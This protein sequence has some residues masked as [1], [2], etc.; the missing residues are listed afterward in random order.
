MGAPVGGGEPSAQLKRGLARSAWSVAA[1]RAE[2]ETHVEVGR[3]RWKLC[4]LQCGDVRVHQR[5]A[6]Q[7]SFRRSLPTAGDQLVAQLVAFPRMPLALDV[8]QRERRFAVLGEPGL[9]ALERCAELLLAD[10]DLL[11]PVGERWGR[12]R[13]H[14]AGPSRGGGRGRAG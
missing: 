14:R 2:V 9:A 3:G 10:A 5:V 7:K 1:L 12:A 11:V 4:G 8:E 13:R 6:F